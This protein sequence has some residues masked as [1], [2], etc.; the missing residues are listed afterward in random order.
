MQKIKLFIAISCEFFDNLEEY[1]D[2]S[3]IGREFI[4]KHG[5]YF[6]THFREFCTKNLY[7]C[8]GK[9]P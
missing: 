1:D 4:F 7:T 3:D 9:R 2:E 6:E 5:D 8:G